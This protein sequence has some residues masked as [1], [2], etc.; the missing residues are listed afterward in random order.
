MKE[1]NTFLW[2]YYDKRSREIDSVLREREGFCGIEVKYRR[3]TDEKSVR[4]I[5]PLKKCFLLSKVDFRRSEST[6]VVPVDIFLSLLSVSQRN[7]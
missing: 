4:R 7:L 5:A 1:Y 6:L 2:Y 3:D